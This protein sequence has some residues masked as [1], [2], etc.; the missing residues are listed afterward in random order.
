MGGDSPAP[1]G[2][3]GQAG[4]APGAATLWAIVPKVRGA[5]HQAAIVEGVGALL[6][7][8]LPRY[9]VTTPLRQAH[10]LAQAAHETDSFCVLEEYASGRA[11]EG[12]R[13]LGNLIPGDGMRFKGRGILQTTGRS[14]YARA[15][16]RLGLDLL[17]HPELLAEPRAALEAA[18]LY[19][20]DRGIN[21]AADRDDV[22]AVTRLINGGLTGLDAREAFT[23]RAKAALGR[24]L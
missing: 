6:A 12:R 19:W 11:S 7:E 17:N 20:Q 16:K 18:C 4:A 22:R 9:G 10:F 5:K 3:M 21:A 23:A 1:L 14:N 13:D 8:L 2:L 24:A 15:A